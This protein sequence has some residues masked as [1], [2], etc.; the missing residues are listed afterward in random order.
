MKWD[1]VNEIDEYSNEKYKKIF[2]K[3]TLIIRNM[4]QSIMVYLAHLDY[5][6][7]VDTKPIINWLTNNKYIWLNLP[8]EV[9]RDYLD[10][11]LDW[12]LPSSLKPFVGMS[13]RNYLHNPQKFTEYFSQ[14]YAK[15]YEGEEY[16]DQQT[17]N[18]IIGMQIVSSDWKYKY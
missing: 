15:S 10:Q 3:R 9:G 18:N 17:I 11:Y 1:I 7:F 8:C 13:L 2:N 4:N 12:K 6:F 16:W 5:D 14:R